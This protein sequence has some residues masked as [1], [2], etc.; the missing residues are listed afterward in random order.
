MK[1][2]FAILLLIFAV[3]DLGATVFTAKASGDW[4]SGSTWSGGDG[5]NTCHTGIPCMTDTY[6]GGPSNG[7]TANLG[8]FAVTCAGGG[9]VCTVGASNGNATSC[10]AGT[11]AVVD[12]AG[13]SLTIGGSAIFVYAGAV[14]LQYG[15]FVAQAG[16]KIYHDSSWTTSP[17]NYQFTDNTGSASQTAGWTIGGSGAP[18]LWEGDSYYSPNACRLT[19]QGCNTNCASANITGCKAGSLAGNAGIGN[20]GYGSATNTTFK[21]IVGNGNVLWYYRATANGKNMTFTNV[22]FINTGQV[23]VRSSATTTFTFDGVYCTASTAI[24]SGTPKFFTYGSVLTGGASVTIKNSYLECSMDVSVG[25]A[26]ITYANSVFKAPWSAGAN[27]TPG[28]SNLYVGFL[29]IDSAHSDQSLYYYDAWIAGTTEGAADKGNL[30]ATYITNSV[31]WVPRN[32]KGGNHLHPSDQHW[33]NLLGG[34]W[35]QKNNVYGGFGDVDTNPA[36]IGSQIGHPAGGNPA[37]TTTITISGNVQPCGAFGR[38]TFMGVGIFYSV[39]GVN[40]GNI[41]PGAVTVQNNV[42]CSAVGDLTTPALNGGGFASAEQGTE[43]NA[44]NVNANIFFRADGVGVGAVPELY[45][46]TADGSQAAN[47]PSLGGTPSFHSVNY[48]AVINMAPAFANVAPCGTYGNACAW[49]TIGPKTTTELMIP[50]Q[51]PQ[52]VEPTRSVL[53]FGTYLNNSGLYPFTNYTSPQTIDI[54]VGT[55]TTSY[56]GAWNPSHGSY[57]VGDVVYV[58]GSVTGYANAY[59]GRRS[60]WICKIA[61]TAASTN[62]PVIGND[63]SNPYMGPTAFW[64]DA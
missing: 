44:T 16:F 38:G 22:K 62:Q 12:T 48:N 46:Y 1:R 15:T 20:V 13:G 52:M 61:H 42:Y 60:Y 33:S 7:D 2:T 31:L 28:V 43:Y 30:P 37:S 23:G 36:T 39:A 14:C 19:G 35:I 18:S 11:A 58:D 26:G 49:A 24:S 4:N 54:G 8:G 3:S 55:V 41:A 6:S 27:Y 57:N 21:D 47:D 45:S 50:N 53:D 59:G 64:E 25:S 34:S 56:Q 51:M 17:V 10:T 9:E 32:V 5:S 40:G 63:A 29:N